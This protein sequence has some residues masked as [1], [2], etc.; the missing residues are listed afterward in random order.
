MENTHIKTATF[1]GSGQSYV[2]LDLHAQYGARYQQL[3]VVLRLLLVDPHAPI[4]ANF[5]HIFQLPY[6]TTAFQYQSFDDLD[7][8]L[9]Q[10]MG[11]QLDRFDQDG[12]S[13]LL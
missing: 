12:H 5:A 7:L 4:A 3:P 13:Q 1:T 2:F 11:R 8:L 10:Q 6:L 9:T